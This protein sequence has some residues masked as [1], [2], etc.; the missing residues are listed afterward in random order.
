MSDPQKQI[1]FEIPPPG[2]I[3]SADLHSLIE[4]KLESTAPAGK[5]DLVSMHIETQAKFVCKVI[6]AERK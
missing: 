5:K 4:Q 1:E 3:S 6:Y 2:S